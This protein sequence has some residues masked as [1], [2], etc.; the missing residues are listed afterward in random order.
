MR[1]GDIWWVDFGEPRGSAPGFERPCVVVSANEYNESEL[2]TVVVAS[3]TTNLKWEHAP[4]NFRVLAR[5]SGLRK[6]SVVLVAQ[7]STVDRRDVKRRAG[8]LADEL[9]PRLD[10]GLRLALG[11]K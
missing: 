5:Q 1:R 3:M 9:W 7:I 2:N 6:P 11:L 10:L 8:R 4:G